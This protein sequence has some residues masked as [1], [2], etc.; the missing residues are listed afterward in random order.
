MDRES[1][2]ALSKALALTS[3]LGVFPL[4]VSVFC[5]EVAA[6]IGPQI[7]LNDVFSQ[8]TPD[9]FWANFFPHSKG[10]SR[11]E[12]KKQILKTFKKHRADWRKLWLVD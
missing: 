1:L 11:A 6:S 2:L 3:S 7:G 8:I 5:A 10:F 4:E 12:Q 9:E